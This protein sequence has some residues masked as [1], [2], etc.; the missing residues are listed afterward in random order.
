MIFYIKQFN[1]PESLNLEKK[2]KI[3]IV[4][5]NLLGIPKIF[6]V[7]CF[8]LF[9]ESLLNKM[10]IWSFEKCALIW[11]FLLFYDTLL[12]GYTVFY[13][14]SLFFWITRLYLFIPLVKFLNLSANKISKDLKMSLLTFSQADLRARSIAK[15]SVHWSIISLDFSFSQCIICALA[16]KWIYRKLT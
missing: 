13:I 14:E 16:C 8:A 1:W 5:K 3:Y 15:K 9:C 4:L 2:V 6:A 7:A 11:D 10:K 12:W